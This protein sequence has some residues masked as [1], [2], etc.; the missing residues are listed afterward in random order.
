MS[1]AVPERIPATQPAFSGR[2]PGPTKITARDLE[3][4]P[5]DDPDKTI[6]LLDQVVVRDLASAIGV[7]PFKIVAELLAMEQFKNADEVIDFETASVIARKHG[8][9][10]EKPPPGSLVL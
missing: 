1:D 4:S 10:A 2:P 6:Y 3:D 9:Q 5:P 7:K 8:Y